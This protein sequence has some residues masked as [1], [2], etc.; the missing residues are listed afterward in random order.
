MKLTTPSTKYKH[1]YLE[2]I[3]EPESK[4][5]VV[6]PPRPIYGES[7]DDFV[8][9]RTNLSIA[10]NFT[11]RVPMTEFWL[12]DDDVFI[13]RTS[14]FHY[15]NSHLLEIIGHVGY[16][17]RPTKRKMGYGKKILE[18]ALIEARKMGIK[19]V[20]V[21][22]DVDNLASKKVIEANGGKLENIV[23]NGE[24]P[25]KMRYWIT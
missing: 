7:F 15:L 5:R 8:K 1:S 13:G 23:P 11:D 12:V 3:S 14:I 20:L 21:T 2:A 4:T 9:S 16:W 17:I 10:Q 22:C 18:L 19:D 6:P 25:L 24:N